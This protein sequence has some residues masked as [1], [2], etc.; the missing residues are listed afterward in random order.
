MEEVGLHLIDP[1]LR[2]VMEEV[3]LHLQVGL[4]QYQKTGLHQYQKVGLHLQ[5]D[6]LFWVDLHLIDWK[7]VLYLFQV[8]LHYNRLSC[9]YY[10]LDST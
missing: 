5:V 4:H 1:D 7:I 8:D 2:L 3:V 6:Y 10:R 9:I